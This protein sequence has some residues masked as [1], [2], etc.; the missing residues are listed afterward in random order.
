[1]WLVTSLKLL[2]QDLT[3]RTL[4]TKKQANRKNRSGENVQL[5]KFLLEFAPQCLEL[6]H[7]RWGCWTQGADLWSSL[8]SQSSQSVSSRFNERPCRNK[9]GAGWLGKLLVSV[10]PP[11]VHAQAHVNTHLHTSTCTHTWNNEKVKYGCLGDQNSENL[12]P[13]MLK[14]THKF[15]F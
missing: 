15:T 11:S 13:Y 1:M 12:H 10:W 5:G 9:K 4:F 8:A 6:Q 14:K 3:R 2:N 7:W